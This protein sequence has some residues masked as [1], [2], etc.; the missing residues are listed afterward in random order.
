MCLEC[1]E[2][3]E[4]CVWEGAGKHA[5]LSRKGLAPALSHWLCCAR[6]S[7]GIYCCSLCGCM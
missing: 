7:A 6:G 2:K 4:F 3:Q 1:E 5:F